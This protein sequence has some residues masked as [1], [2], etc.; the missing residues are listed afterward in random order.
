MQ[1]IPAVD[2]LDGAVVR[3]LHGDYDAVTTYAPDPA[4]MAR[5]WVDEGASL[6]HVVDLAG[7]RRGDPDADLWKTMAEA[8]LPFQVGGGIR[9]ASLAAA[10]VDAGAQRVVVGSAAVHSAEA[11]AAIVDAVG[12]DRVV[13]AIDVR[14]GLA[15]GSGWE[16]GGVA[17]DVVVQRVVASGVPTALVTG[18]ERDGAMNGPDTDLLTLVNIIAPDLELIA[19]GGVGSIN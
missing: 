13:A 14:S 4:Q 19:S 1:I 6:V 12:P 9:D 18:I 5:Q 15:R 17:L 8:G 7:A 10:A 11:L 16:D 2:V 3:L